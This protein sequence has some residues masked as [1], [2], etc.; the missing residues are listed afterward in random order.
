MNILVLDDDTVLLRALDGILSSHGHAVTCVDKPE[1]AISLVADSEY[2][3]VLVD[4]HMQNQTGA[5][6][7]KHAKLPRRTKALLVTGNV[8]RDIINE[9]F[10]LGAAGYLIKPFESFHRHV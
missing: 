2:D 4:Y 7:M 3:F 5:W 10:A 9:M 8:S 6:F 1:A